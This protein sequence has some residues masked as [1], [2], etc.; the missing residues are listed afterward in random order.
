M[1]VICGWQ[2][3]TV[4]QSHLITMGWVSPGRRGITLAVVVEGVE[5][6]GRAI[7]SVEVSCGNCRRHPL[8]VCEK[9]DQC[10]PTCFCVV[11][12][13]P[14][15]VHKPFTNIFTMLVCTETLHT[16]TKM[17]N[18]LNVARHKKLIMLAAM[19]N[20]YA[21]LKCSFLTGSF[22]VLSGCQLLFFLVCHV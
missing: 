6:G 3:M 20:K 7:L 19:P 18:T 13:C 22:P 16:G 21:V 1:I 17:S 14:V 15:R 9:C 12:I 8:V 5:V 10:L 2:H 4:T 11:S